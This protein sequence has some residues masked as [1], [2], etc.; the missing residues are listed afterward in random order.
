MKVSKYIQALLLALTCASLPGLYGCSDD[1]GYPGSDCPEGE[2]AKVTIGLDLDDRAM[3]TRGELQEGLDYKINDLWVAIYNVATGQRTG[4][5]YLNRSEDNSPHIP[6][7][8]TIDALSGRSHIVGVANATHRYGMDSSS[9]EVRALPDLLAEADTWEKFCNISAGF[10]TRGNA[11]VETPLNAL[12]MTGTFT[13][14]EHTDGSRTDDEPVDIRPGMSKPDGA[15]HLRRLISHVSFRVR[16]NQANIKDFKI[17][18]WRVVNL[19]NQTWLHERPDGEADVNVADV[20][21]LGGKSYVSSEPLTE[22]SESGDITSFDF[23][24]LENKRQG[25]APPA[26]ETDPYHYRERQFKDPATGENTGKFISLVNSAQSDDPNNN[27]TYVEFNV[28][29]RMSVDEKGRPL[30]DTDISM[31]R[32]ETRYYVH[33]GYIEGDDSGKV[34]DFN[35]RRNSKYIY[36]VTINNVSDILV[37]ATGESERNP[38]VEGIVSD[39]MEA[40]YDVDA[41][42]SA[43]NVYMT[44]AELRNFEYLVVAYDLNGREIYIDS[45]QTGS[46]PDDM[47]RYMS[48]VEFRPTSGENV[49]ADYKPRTGSNSD[50]KTYRLDEMKGKT[51]GWYTMFVDEYVYEDVSDGNESNSTNWHGYVNRPDRRVWLN[52]QAERSADGQSLYYKSKYSLSQRSIQTYYNM[53]SKSGLGVEHINES[54]GLNLRNNYNAGGNGNTLSGRYNLAYRLAGHTSWSSASFTW[55]DNSYRWNTFL[56]LNEFQKVNAINNQGINRSARTHHLPKIRTISG[57]YSKYDPD[58]SSSAM[59]I[60]AITACLNRNRD[61]DGDGRID[62]SEV[63]WFVPTRNQYVR[64]ILGRRS[65]VTPILDVESVTKLPYT[66]NGENSSMLFYTSEGRQIWAMEGTSDS[67]WM[68]YGGGAP[69]EVRCVRNLGGNMSVINT[70]NI[71]E[72]AFELRA[73]TNIVDLA[74]YDSKSVRSEA[75]VTSNSPMPVHHLYDQRYNRCYRAFEVAAPEY[76]IPCASMTGLDIDSYDWAAYLTTHNPCSS[77]VSKTGKEGWRVPNQKELTIMSILG[78]APSY[79][80]NYSSTVSYFDKSGYAYGQNPSDLPGSL[81]VKFRYVMK[82]TGSGMATQGG[83]GAKN[84]GIRCVRDYVE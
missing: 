61:I 55:S 33:L 69:W 11:S 38:A 80:Y 58:R 49:L 31:R 26:T 83:D 7:E 29:M 40:Q 73:G 70:T 72:P 14:S 48:W 50:G 24:Q 46:I 47:R 37:E 18:S 9:S 64:I 22:V 23:W 77:L 41:H 68:A 30:S 35:C 82:T 45:Q 21:S 4:I 17:K 32:V 5:Y 78:V 16:Y 57:S 3:L 59:Y 13:S 71:T 81:G 12:V 10:D 34:R 25:L 76:D 15:L 51:A 36:N 84:F 67:P 44:A 2:K 19:P 20:R 60:E 53:T 1:L 6:R 27:A 54:Y 39:V 42:Y 28:E 79:Y 75:Y 66:D 62:A 74:H 63:R 8:I 56:S 43:V 65:L 52:V